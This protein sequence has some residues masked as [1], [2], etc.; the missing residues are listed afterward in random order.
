MCVSSFNFLGLTE[1]CNKKLMFWNLRRRR[2]KKK[3]KS[4]S[5]LIQVYIIHQPSVHVWTQ[6]QLSLSVPEKR[7]MIFLNIWKLERKKN[8]E[9]K[10]R[11]SR[12]SLVLFQIIQQIIHNQRNYKKLSA[13]D[14]PFCIKL[15]Q[16]G[17]TPKVWKQKKWWAVSVSNMHHPPSTQQLMQSER[18]HSRRH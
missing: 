9:I 16:W 12:R 14:V 5:S 6:L 3:K 2:K 1:K 11:I 10:G 7:E 15:H 17:S 18:H 8:K 13:T 4:T